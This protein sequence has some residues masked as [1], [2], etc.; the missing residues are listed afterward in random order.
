M[1]AETL[2]QARTDCEAILRTCR[3]D[4][5]DALTRQITAVINADLSARN[6]A[7]IMGALAQALLGNCWEDLLERDAEAAIELFRICVRKKLGRQAPAVEVAG[8][9]EVVE[10]EERH[11]RTQ[12]N[13]GA[14]T[15]YAYGIVPTLLWDVYGK[16]HRDRGALLVKLKK[17]R[18]ET[19][20]C[21]KAVEL[22]QR[23]M[24]GEAVAADIMAW[25]RQYGYLL[26]DFM[27][28]EESADRDLKPANVSE[29][30]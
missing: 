16:A 23:W 25:S 11:H 7:D 2:A 19:K 18:E 10:I 28:G 24:N 22:A 21:V 4:V 6:R 17:S 15:G 29:G 8:D 9:A 13:V 26:P 30:G 5:V 20:A 14:A 3:P 1:S 27:A 12:H